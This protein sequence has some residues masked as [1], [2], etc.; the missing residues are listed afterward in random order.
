MGEKKIPLGSVRFA[1]LELENLSDQKVCIC[2]GLHLT[3]CPLL[4]SYLPLKA[5]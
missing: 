2:L 5:F 1:G 4:V 3:K